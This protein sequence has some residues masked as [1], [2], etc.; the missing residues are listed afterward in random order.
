MRFHPLRVSTVERLTDDAV[1]IEFDVPPELRDEFRFRPGQHVSVRSPVLG[2]GARRSYSLCVPATSGRVR[3]GVKRVPG[4]VFSAY[5]AD[6]LSAGDVLEVMTPTGSFSPALDPARARGYAA[7]AAGSGIT[8]VL[9]ILATALEVEPASTAALVYVNRSA[10]S[11]MFL[12]ELED[13]KNR[14]TDRFQLVHVFVW[15]P[16]GIDLLAGRP[17][18]DRLGRLLDSLVPVSTVDEWFL[19][20]PL[21]LTEAARAVLLERGVP[22]GDVHREL[23]H[24]GAPPPRPAVRAA[25][26]AP[27]SAVTVVLGGRTQ[28]LVVPRDGESVLEGILRVRADAPYACRN[29]VCGTCRAKVLEGEVRMDAD[30]AL[31]PAEQAA[32]FVLTCQAHPVSERVTLD[33]DR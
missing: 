4:G 17:D 33:F 11:V 23:F 24:V 32:G 14:Y 2:D 8:P 3:I 20:G 13:L 7:I 29:A 5:A 26:A 16:R 19:C 12:E 9:S 15:E 30:Y 10:A 28:T 6:E 1:A 21:P 31:E 22:A 18:A 27:G 25:A